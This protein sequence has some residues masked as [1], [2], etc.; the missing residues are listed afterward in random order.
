MLN[1]K[2]ASKAIKHTVIVRLLTVV[3][4]AESALHLKD[5]KQVPAATERHSI[6]QRRCCLSC[7]DSDSLVCEEEAPAAVGIRVN[8][9]SR[10]S[11][12]S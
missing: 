7:N 1:A 3:A 12:V 5:K 10:F 8:S 9:G 4:E 2:T 6:E 11:G